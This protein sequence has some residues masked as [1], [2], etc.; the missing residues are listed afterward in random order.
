[1]LMRPLGEVCLVKYG[2]DVDNHTDNQNLGD[3]LVTIR[4]AGPVSE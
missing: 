3:R 1:M 2:I 4:Y